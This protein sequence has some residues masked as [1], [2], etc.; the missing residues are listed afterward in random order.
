MENGK[1][2]KIHISLENGSPDSK[3]DF[4]EKLGFGTWR[5]IISARHI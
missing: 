3:E 1:F 4:S 5:F 2:E